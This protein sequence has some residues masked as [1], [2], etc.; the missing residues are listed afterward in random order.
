MLK[1][2]ILY[3]FDYFA[4]EIFFNKYGPI[5]SNTNFKTLFY[6]KSNGNSCE[7]IYV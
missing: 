6:N 3:L 2:T 1:Y 7:C 5:K 4:S